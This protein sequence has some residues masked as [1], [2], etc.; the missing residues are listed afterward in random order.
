MNGLN[1]RDETKR[2]HSLAPTDNMNYLIRFFISKSKVKVTA[3][4]RDSEG[5][6]VDAGCQSPSSNFC[7]VCCCWWASLIVITN[8]A[9]KVNM[10]RITMYCPIILLLGNVFIY[11]AVCVQFITESSRSEGSLWSLPT[12]VF[13]QRQTVQTDDIFRLWALHQLEH[14][15]SWIPLF[16]H[17]WQ[18]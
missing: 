4:S 1:S 17:W 18:T 2:E 11:E 15:V 6:R 12:W 5:I 3:G 14:E 9:G 16:V 13:Q 7:S 8:L 10:F